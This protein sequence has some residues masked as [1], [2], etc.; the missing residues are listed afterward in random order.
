MCVRLYHVLRD[1]LKLAYD[2]NVHQATTVTYSRGG[3]Y[4]LALV[5]KTMIYVYRT[6]GGATAPTLVS[7]CT[8]HAMDQHAFAATSMITAIQWGVDDTHFYACDIHGGLHE[9]KLSMKE[10]GQFKLCKA[11]TADP[12]T[13]TLHE[14]D[15]QNNM[16]KA[17]SGHRRRKYIYSA[18]ATSH[19]RTTGMYVI[20][21]RTG[22]RYHR[23][24]CQL[25]CVLDV[26][27]DFKIAHHC[28][29]IP[30]TLTQLVQ[31]VN[32]IQQCTPS[33]RDWVKMTTTFVVRCV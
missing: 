27:W 30:V 31:L 11:T 25:C 22:W 32:V 1:D 8:G 15:K 13:Q 19:D 16:R 5:A 28:L 9:W 4:F 3:N 14:K 10:R 17:T 7:R 26:S 29:S 21:S 20:G 2:V 23:W 6:F 33:R 12:A 18:L 24:R